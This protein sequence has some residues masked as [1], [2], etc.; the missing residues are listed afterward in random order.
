MSCAN[1]GVLLDSELYVHA[2]D[3]ATGFWTLL[4]PQWFKA[5]PDMR[6]VVEGYCSPEC[7]LER[8]LTSATRRAAEGP[9]SR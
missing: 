5:T 4:A 6:G 2:F 8:H 1:C 3:T 7:S 9:C